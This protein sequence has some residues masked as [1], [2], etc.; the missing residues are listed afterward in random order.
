MLSDMCTGTVI[1]SND[2]TTDESR[3]DDI[4]CF[5]AQNLQ[6]SLANELL[7]LFEETRD[8]LYLGLV[9]T[10]RGRRLDPAGSGYTGCRPHC[11]TPRKQG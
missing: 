6:V 1:S 3:R 2:V 9:L 11:R 7:E 5:L 4:C 8:R 10:L